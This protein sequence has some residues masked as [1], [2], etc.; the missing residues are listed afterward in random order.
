MKIR[1]LKK[2]KIIYTDKD[3]NTKCIKFIDWVG[4][5]YKQ[6]GSYKK[7]NIDMFIL[8]H[9]TILEK[10]WLNAVAQAQNN[11]IKNMSFFQKVKLFFKKFLKL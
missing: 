2:E 4:V 5:M 9:R 3:G 11:S 10:N 8:K 6:S 7:M 1:D